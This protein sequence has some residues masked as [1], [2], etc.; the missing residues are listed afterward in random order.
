MQIW[1]AYAGRMEAV[2]ADDLGTIRAGRQSAATNGEGAATVA[3]AV[4]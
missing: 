3:T 4:P 1:N 2:R